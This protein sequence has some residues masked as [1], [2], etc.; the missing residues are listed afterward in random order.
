M[1]NSRHV[2]TVF[3]VVLFALFPSVAWA[4]IFSDGD[5]LPAN[6]T[7]STA[8]TSSSESWDGPPAQSDI[9]FNIDYGDLDVFG[10]NF[11]SVSLPEAPRSDP[12]DAAT[13]GIFLSA[14]NDSL[15]QDAGRWSMAAVTPNGLNVGTGT[16]T[17][18]FKMTVDVFHSAGTGIVDSNGVVGSLVG[19]SNYTHLGIGQANT[20]VQVEDLNAPNPDIQDPNIGFPNRTGQGLG[21]LISG[22]GGAEN[23]STDDYLPIYG[24]A[25]YRDETGTSISGNTYR[26]VPTSAS[27]GTAIAHGRSGLAGQILNQYWIDQGL[28]YTID[29]PGDPTYDP[30][31]P[32]R[33]NRYTGDAT[34]FSVDPE[35]AENF[36]LD[37]IDDPNQHGFPWFRQ[38]YGE[39]LIETTGAPTHLSGLFVENTDPNQPALGS[40]NR[41]G[42]GVVSNRWVTHELYWVD[43]VFTYVMDGVP[44][45]QIDPEHDPND[46]SAGN[47]YDPYSESGSVVLGFF[48]RFNSVALSPEG[49]NFVVYDNL[50]VEAVSSGSAPNLLDFYEGLGFLLAPT[51]DVD[52]NNDGRV[53][54]LDFLKLQRENPALIP[55]WEAQYGTP[56]GDDGDVNGDGRVNGQDFLQLQR[57][58]PSLMAAWEAQ[59]GT[60]LA[61]SAT[62]VPEPLSLTITMLGCGILATM[63]RAR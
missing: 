59:Y 25:V 19:S 53:D 30:N 42:V 43:G 40:N 63:R 26:G 34:H 10:G 24:G 60:P 58:D 56:F 11:V 14:N 22:D 13:T 44:L 29:D 17:P 18:N 47:V 21:L 15:S 23:G 54:G 41:F 20:I 3:A 57:E 5:F 55:D 50:L 39:P 36:D 16:A 9:R 61:S 1:T 35:D 32:K 37:E 8:L 45:L 48:D 33:L 49:A 4:A 52:V 2:C 31:N 46:I 38:V 27:D 28:G 12:N 62:T 7:P 6:Y 51:P